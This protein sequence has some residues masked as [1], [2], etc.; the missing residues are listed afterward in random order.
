MRQNHL[1]A[2]SILTF[3]T[4]CLTFLAMGSAQALFT[5]QKEVERESRLQWLTM[6]R[7][8]PRPADPRVQ[9]RLPE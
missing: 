4:A 1:V 8:M 2:R 7:S 3:A 6:K 9:T 5:S